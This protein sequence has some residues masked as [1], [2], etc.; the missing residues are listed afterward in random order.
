M[1][2]VI[3]GIYMRL[4]ARRSLR[5]VCVV[6]LI[7]GTFVYGGMCDVYALSEIVE[8]NKI[9]KDEKRRI[10]QSARADIDMGKILDV[11][12]SEAF[13]SIEEKAKAN[14]NEREQFT[15]NTEEPMVSV[16]T[17]RRS[18]GNKVLK[19]FN[20]GVYYQKQGNTV[21]AIEEY[22]RVL[23]LD[24]DNAEAHNNLGTIYKEQDDLD[25]AMEHFQHVV[26]FNPGMDEAHN[27][28][29]LIYYLKGNQRGAVSEFQKAIELN[30]DNLMSQI[31]MGLVY[32]SQGLE[33]KAI[34]TLEEVLSIE[35]FQVEAHYNLAIL[36]EGL[37]HLE[38]AAWHYT[39]FVDNAGAGYIDLTRKVSEHIKKLEVTSGNILKE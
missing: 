36:Y 28:L 12:D 20:L 18:P 2:Q 6:A 17:E 13:P 39:R 22:G 30:P 14:V 1:I 38:R 34:D 3:C 31:N 26:S 35:P 11:D 37:G 27:N 33:R 5:V 7:A 21:K 23:E 16:S 15:E 8:L 25:K 24:P 29:G 32:K 9:V 19:L 4:F 10:E